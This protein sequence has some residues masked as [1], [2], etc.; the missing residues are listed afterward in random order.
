MSATELE[1]TKS[2]PTLIVV[3][4]PIQQQRPVSDSDD[5]DENIT[6]PATPIFQPSTLHPEPTVLIAITSHAHAPPLQPVPD[7]QY[8]LRTLPSPG[9][10]K[11]ASK[12]DGRGKRARE[13]VKGEAVYVELL[14]RVEQ[15]ALKRGRELELE[16]EQ[17]KVAQDKA[18]EENKSNVKVE[19]EKVPESVKDDDTTVAEAADPETTEAQ[20]VEKMDALDLER[21][22]DSSQLATRIPPKVLRIGVSSEIGRDRSVAFVEELSRK[23][24]PVEWAVEILHRDV[25]K[26]W[27]L[28]KGKGRS[29]EKGGRRKT[30]RGGDLTHGED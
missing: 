26:Q 1:P 16:A 11:Y 4:A 19:T 21:V 20:V 27:A 14:G 29:G 3:S 8:D 12:Y 2:A 30:L 17:E 18:R 9:P 7:L 6:P 24:W 25:D 28:R 15:E 10:E 5:S 13:W 23:K 22:E